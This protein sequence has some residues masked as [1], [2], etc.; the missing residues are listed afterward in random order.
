M[1]DMLKEDT[2]AEEEKEQ[3]EEKQKERELQTSHKVKV[4]DL[5]HFE[6]KTTI[7]NFAHTSLKFVKTYSF[8]LFLG[9]GQDV[10]GIYPMYVHVYTS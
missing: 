6:C 10:R 2:D 7:Q 1:L 9:L 3:E 4:P 5:K 8:H